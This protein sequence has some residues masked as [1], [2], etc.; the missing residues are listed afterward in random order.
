MTKIVNVYIVYE[1]NAWPTN[2]TNN[3]KFKNYLFGANSVVRSCDKEKWVYSSCGITSDSAGSWSFDNDS[4]ENV[5]TFGVDNSYSSYSDNCKNN[6]V[7]LGEEPTFG[8]NGSFG[9]PEKSLVLILVKQIQSFLFVNGKE[10]YKF[11]AN[12]K[13]I[14]FPTQFCLGSKSNGF[15]APESREVSL[16][17]NVYD[18]SVDYNS[19]DKY[20]ILNIQK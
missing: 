17:G 2:P 13:N 16:N 20:N 18:F 19:I 10:I 14:N 4:A 11:K 8:I 1:L 7:N 5:K 12:N 6:F 3:F 9:L 15:S